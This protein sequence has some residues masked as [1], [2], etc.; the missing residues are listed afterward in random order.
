[1]QEPET[2]F[3]EGPHRK[4]PGRVPH[5]AE[6]FVPAVLAAVD[7]NPMAALAG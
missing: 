5:P 3:S 6:G 1:M 4:G 2:P 7:V